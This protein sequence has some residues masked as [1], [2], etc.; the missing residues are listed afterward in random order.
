MSHLDDVRQE[1]LDRTFEIVTFPP[2]AVQ[3]LDDATFSQ[4]SLSFLT[5]TFE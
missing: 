1:L 5:D 2:V 3:L 4:I